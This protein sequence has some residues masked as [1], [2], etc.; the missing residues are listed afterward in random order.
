MAELTGVTAPAAAVQDT[1]VTVPAAA[2]QELEY[3]T[4]ADIEAMQNEPDG[5]V[6]PELTVDEI[7]GNEEAPDQTV[8]PKGDDAPPAQNQPKTPATPE[9]PNQPPELPAD[10][11]KAFSE[12][13]KSERAK[14]EREAKEAAKR[15]FQEQYG[16][17]PEEAQ[18]LRLDK[19]ARE[20]MEKYPDQVKS[21]EFARELASSQVQPKTA[22]TPP[23]QQQANGNPEKTAW[24]ESIKG[25][26]A[27]IQTVDPEF[28]F[29]DHF[30]NSPAFKSSVLTGGSIRD[31]LKAESQ[32]TEKIAQ[33]TEAAKA[34]G[35]KEA[36]EAIRKS[37]SAAMTPVPSSKGQRPGTHE[38][39]AA[40]RERFNAYVKMHGKAPNPYYSG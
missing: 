11:S 2:G 30:N 14:I 9:S 26:E 1:G 21:I 31:A 20:L 23:A 29:V 8:A 33:Q 39:T 22:K 15:E 40:E 12:R 10:A 7:L 25:Q 5:D 32:E 18:E 35:K 34:Q 19:R 36:V 6:E 4:Q 37:G 17:T 16:I 24:V 38:M 28:S 27:E 3:P 13:L